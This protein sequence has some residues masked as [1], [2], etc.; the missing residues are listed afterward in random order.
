MSQWNQSLSLYKMIDKPRN[1][2]NEKTKLSY[3]RKKRREN[4]YNPLA[5]RLAL[6][7]NNNIIK[8]ELCRNYIVIR[9]LFTF[10]AFLTN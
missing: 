6:F 9:R 4:H 2:I 8:R 3:V 5:A 7:S 1:T 10:S